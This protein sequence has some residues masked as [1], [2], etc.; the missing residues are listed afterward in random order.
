MT[1]WK[2]KKNLLE[3]ETGQIYIYK[4]YFIE[5]NKHCTENNWKQW[6]EKIK[7]SGIYNTNHGPLSQAWVD[8]KYRSLLWYVMSTKIM[9]NT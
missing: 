4:K 9:D 1:D 3:Q 8:G 6:P 2:R 7:N 5:S